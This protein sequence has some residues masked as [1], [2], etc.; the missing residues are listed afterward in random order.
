M[1]FKIILL[2]L[3]ATAVTSYFFHD[4]VYHQFYRIY[5]TYVQKSGES[6]ILKK[7]E[8][9][10]EEKR[11][12]ELQ[13]YLEKR[14]ILYPHSR[15]LKRLAAKGYLKTGDRN[16]AAR[17]LLESLED[18]QKE[19]SVFKQALDLLYQEK[20][21]GDV[22]A[23][24]RNYPALKDA[25]LCALYGVSLY[26]TGRYGEALKYL[27]IAEKEGSLDH[28]V[29]HNA[30]LIYERQNRLP[31]AT[32]YLEKAF[33]LNPLDRSLRQSL[34]RVYTQQKMFTKAESLLRRSL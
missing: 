5:Y 7:A 30:G 15:P 20:W 34:I 17:L 11:Y 14:L 3:I 2:F 19:I 24:M 25:D 8:R 23:A 31:Q 33:R 32:A 26:K 21:Y 13:K 27:L 9:L 16:R 1:R 4:Q 28:E 6:S 18:P 10:Y 22:V 12:I 29:Y